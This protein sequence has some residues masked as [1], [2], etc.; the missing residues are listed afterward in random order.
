[1]KRASSFRRTLWPI[2]RI[3]AW[4]SWASVAML[5]GSLPASGCRRGRRGGSRLRGGLDR[6]DDVHV[7]RAATDVPRDRPADVVVRR[8]GVALEQRGAD[9]HHP[10][11]AVA[12]L[13]PVLLLERGL[14][15]MQAVRARQTLD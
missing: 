7:A 2:P 10:G 11:S 5:V 8:V 15:G 4:A 12:A 1:M 9:E 14:H 3:S 13:E 6:F